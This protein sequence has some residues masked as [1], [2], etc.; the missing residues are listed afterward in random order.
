MTNYRSPVGQPSALPDVTAPAGQVCAGCYVVAEV[1]GIVFG[2][3]TTATQTAVVSLGSNGSVVRTSL[4]DGEGLITYTNSQPAG[5]PVSYNSFGSVI[6]LSGAT[7][8]ATSL[9][10]FRFL[11]NIHP[12]RLRLNTKSLQPTL[13]SRPC[14]GPTDAPSPPS[15]ASHLAPHTST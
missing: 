3:V 8:Y 2:G 11:T 4:M 14:Q 10:A 9:N 13:S 12:A 1:A 7:L 6:T 15:H 5:A